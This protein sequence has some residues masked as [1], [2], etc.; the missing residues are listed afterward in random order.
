VYDV[1]PLQRYLHTS[2]K[3]PG[4]VQKAKSWACT[5]CCG[6]LADSVP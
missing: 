6:E 2:P 3:G 5:A 4:N 1:T